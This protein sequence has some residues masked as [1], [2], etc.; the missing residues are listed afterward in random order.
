MRLGSGERSRHG[1]STRGYC[2]TDGRTICGFR[3]GYFSVILTS[4]PE[5][6][7]AAIAALIFSLRA[8][9]S[10]RIPAPAPSPRISGSSGTLPL[11]SQHALPWSVW[12][13]ESTSPPACEIIDTPGREIVIDLVLRLIGFQFRAAEML[14]HVSLMDC[15]NLDADRLA[16][17]M[18]RGDIEIAV[19]GPNDD[20][21]RV[22]IHVGEVDG[23]L[24]LRRD[25]HGAPDQVNLLGRQGRND[26]VPR[27]F[28]DLALL[29]QVLAHGIHQVD[30]PADPFAGSIL[31]GKRRVW[32][33]G[34]AELEVGLHGAGPDDQ[35]E[36]RCRRQLE[37][38]FHEISPCIGSLRWV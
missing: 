8:V 26:A 12:R 27:N 17:Q 16:L 9:S 18:L 25:R 31:G 20:V 35:S 6:V 37:N 19:F 10:L 3:S 29:V 1:L 22:V 30:L 21:G 7:S 38:V 28:H 34:H 13:N 5:A 15:G 24:A 4:S 2:D 14:L 11:S 32:L 36:H 33:C 23:F